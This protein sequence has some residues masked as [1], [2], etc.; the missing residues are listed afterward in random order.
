M[1]RKQWY[2]VG[3][4]HNCPVSYLLP[5]IDAKNKVDAEKILRD[6]RKSAKY[7]EVFWMDFDWIIA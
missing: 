6:K 4:R 1:T 3:S 7:G 2:V 5:R